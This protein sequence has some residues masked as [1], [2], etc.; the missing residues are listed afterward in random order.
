VPARTSHRA[1]QNH[2]EASCDTAFELDQ[3]KSGGACA[4][5]FPGVDNTHPVNNNAPQ[6]DMGTPPGGRAHYGAPEDD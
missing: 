2:A 3:L 6:L 1:Q 4:D 5:D